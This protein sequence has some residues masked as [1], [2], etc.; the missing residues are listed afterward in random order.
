M[1]EAAS[2]F[3]RADIQRQDGR[4]LAQWMRNNNVTR[5]LNENGNIS[6]ELMQLAE[7]APEGTL[8]FH[9][10]QRG[11][12]FLICAG[13]GSSIGFITLAPRAQKECEVV[14]AIGDEA[15]WGRGYGRHALDL[16]LGKAF[17]EM[18][19][20]KVTARIRKGNIR[21]IRAAQHCGMKPVRAAGD[22]AVYEITFGEYIEHRHREG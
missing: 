18:R 4:S 2:V 3:L 21:S 13:D 15:L 22:L 19:R 7:R 12:F 20:E 16:A 5:Y 14:Y 11:R 17:F 6:D 8:S 9:L 10:N 1:N